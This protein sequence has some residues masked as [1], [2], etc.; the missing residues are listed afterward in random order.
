[1]C[2]KRW[3]PSSPSSTA[4]DEVL[5]RERRELGRATRARHLRRGE[6]R[7]RGVGEHVADDRGRLDHRALVARERVETRGEQRL[8]RRGTCS[9]ERSPVARHAPFDRSRTPS[10]TSIRRSCSAKSGFP[11]A[12]VDDTVEDVRVER[13]AAEQALDHRPARR[14]RR[15]A[16]AR[17]ASRASRAPVRMVVD[18]LRPRGAEDQHG[19]VVERLD[20]LLDQLEQRASAQWTSSTTSATGRSA[21]TVLEEPPHPPEELLHGERLGPQ[22][23]HRG[24][25]LGDAVS[26]RVRERGQLPERLR[27]RRRR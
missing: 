27:R 24:E 7:H 4:A 26:G 10:S 18:E 13:P 3:G 21:A 16:P 5:L 19:R 6:R 2:W 8:D 12:A 22:A 1:M 25:T 9:S 20:E 14:P 23:D 17:S 15:A 11:S